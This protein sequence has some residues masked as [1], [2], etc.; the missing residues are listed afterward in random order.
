MDRVLRSN[1]DLVGEEMGGNL[2]YVEDSNRRVSP[3]R[4]DPKEGEEKSELESVVI[5][6]PR[7]WQRIES[8][9]LNFH[10]SLLFL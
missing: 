1:L 4:S 6:I 2:Y 7:F 3:H 9:D 8:R 5:T 10:S